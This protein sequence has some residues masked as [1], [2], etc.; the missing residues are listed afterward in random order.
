[1]RHKLIAAIGVVSLVTL[2][3]NGVH[4]QQRAQSQPLLQSS[5]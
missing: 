4:G 1:M 5:M 3:A 2:F